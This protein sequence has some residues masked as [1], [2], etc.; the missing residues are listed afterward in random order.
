MWNLRGKF[1]RNCKIWIEEGFFFFLE[2]YAR[3][4]DSI[5]R[6]INNVKEFLRKDNA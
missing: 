1:W 2:N 5:T 3:V 6:P 4:L